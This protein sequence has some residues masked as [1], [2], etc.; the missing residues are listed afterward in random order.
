MSLVSEVRKT[1]DC[2]RNKYNGLFLAIMGPDGAGKSTLIEQLEITIGRS[3]EGTFSFH[4]IPYLIRRKRCVSPVTKP[5]GKPPR[6]W[7]FSRLKLG[8]YLL[9]YILGYWLK[10][11]P[12]LWRSTLVLF[13]RYYDDLLIDPRRY[14]YG[15]PIRLARWL[16]R[17]IPRPDLFLVLDVPVEALLERKQELAPEE[18]R[19]QV[20][21]Y[22]RFALET[23][24]AFLLD[25]A[26]PPEDVAR[27]AR[28]I[29]LDHLHARYLSRRHI[30]FPRNPMEELAWLDEALG[31]A[32]TDKGRPTHAWLRLPDG[33]GYLLPLNNSRVFRRGLE[34]YPAQ[35]RKARLGKK[36]LEALARLG[37]KG[38]GLLRIGLDKREGS[39][40]QTLQEVFRRDDLCFAVSLGTPGPHRKPV[41]QVLTPEGKVLGYAK[42]GWNE[43]TKELIENDARMNRKIRELNFPWLRVPGIIHFSKTACSTILVT[44]PL[45]GLHAT[46]WNS[47][48]KEKFTK[49]M[50]MIAD[51]T[52]RDRLFL[53]TPFWKEQNDRLLE[54]S[55]Y[56]AGYQLQT[57]V[58]AL[59]I[60]EDRLGKLQLPWVLRL[61]DATRW[62]VTIDEQNGE[63]KLIDLEYAKEN[64]LVG[65]DLFRFLMDRFS[66]VPDS[67]VSWYYRAAGVD[68]RLA[69]SLQLA[70][71]V[72]LFTEWVLAWK[73][74]NLPIS[75]AARGVLRKIVTT[76]HFLSRQQELEK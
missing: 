2:K 42:V 1:L 51:H 59:E 19:R 56:L 49:A 44:S 12:A 29:I 36:A 35:G 26:L 63:L 16:R 5:H 6:S 7:L 53:D 18:L 24:N 31:I 71:W 10:V 50:A 64:C 21:A 52:R 4:L 20:E 3:F 34:L 67:E 40:L 73:N 28:E 9:L 70:F 57:L 66:I 13:D 72:D 45:E 8:Y 30:W 75:P 22:R 11:C 38:P 23:P 55:G 32:I 62:N 61:G 39:E 54:L 33:R 27:E 37:L 43:A 74:V 69:S 14:R 68:S 25:G 46:R 41:V 48:L 17:F 47:E 60:L 76:I 15:G 58:R 65:W